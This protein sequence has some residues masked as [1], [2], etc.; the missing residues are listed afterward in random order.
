MTSVFLLYLNSSRFALFLI[1]F[2]TVTLFF[3]R[4]LV[5]VS[6]RITVSSLQEEA[7]LLT[8]P[9]RHGKSQLLRSISLDWIHRI[10]PLQAI[11]LR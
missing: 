10:L 1:F 8:I 5:R 7:S 6:L 11:T 2:S 3:F 4:L 9:S